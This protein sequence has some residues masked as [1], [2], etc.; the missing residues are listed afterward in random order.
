VVDVKIILKSLVE[1]L[2][3]SVILMHNHPSGNREPSEA[4]I[5]I[6]KKIK[7]AVSSM[8]IVLLDHLIIGGNSY[9]SFA[10]EGLL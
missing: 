10:D 1:H 5:K 8:D 6:T 9:F 3:S 2:A 7:L 4:D